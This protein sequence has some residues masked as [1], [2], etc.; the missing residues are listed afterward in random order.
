MMM[1]EQNPRFGRQNFCKKI[2]D[3]DERTQLAKGEKY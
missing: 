2:L 3:D 1:G